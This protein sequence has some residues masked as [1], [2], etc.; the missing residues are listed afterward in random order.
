MAQLL[1]STFQKAVEI[2]SPIV[3]RE[4]TKPRFRRFLEEKAADVAIEL[5]RKFTTAKSKKN[6]I[7][8]RGATKF[9]CRRMN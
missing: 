9:K 8:R 3:I 5:A 6:I 7:I 4:V 1:G 2:I